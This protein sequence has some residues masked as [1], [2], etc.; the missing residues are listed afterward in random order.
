[1]DNP[2]VL[3]NLSFSKMFSFSTFQELNKTIHTNRK[4]R[5]M[6]GFVELRANSKLSTFFIHPVDIFL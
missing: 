4:F 1:M 5:C 3:E 6:N 2:P